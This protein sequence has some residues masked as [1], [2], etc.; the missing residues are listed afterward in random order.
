M[1]VDYLTAV[2]AQE[3][4]IYATADSVGLGQRRMTR[5]L[6]EGLKPARRS[7][8]RAAAGVATSEDE[9][10]SYG[11]ST[12]QLNVCVAGCTLLCENIAGGALEWWHFFIYF[13][14]PQTF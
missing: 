14:C 8:T 2:P 12:K 6:P 3:E 10:T 5:R 1:G 4:S 13:F 7:P 9:P 11:M